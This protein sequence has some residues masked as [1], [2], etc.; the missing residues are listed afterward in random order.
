MIGAEL[1]ESRV[2]APAELAVVIIQQ[3]GDRG[4]SQETLAELSRISVRTVQ[5]VENAEASTFDTRRALARA[6]N[7]PDIDIFNKPWPIPNVGRLKAEQARI[8]RETV[9]VALERVMTGRRLREFAEEAESWMLNQVGEIDL[10]AEHVLAELQDYFTDY[11]DVDDCYSATQK[12]AVNADF[13]G[14]IDRLRMLG[15]GIAAGRR[16]IRISFYQP[17]P[18]DGT[19]LTVVHLVAGPANAMPSAIRVPRTGKVSP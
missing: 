16:K 4:W 10:D 12:L 7:W 17:G 1:F 13:Q 11:A 14:M 5:R 2:L 18:M 9:A 8:E 3:R 6:F 19:R 15:A